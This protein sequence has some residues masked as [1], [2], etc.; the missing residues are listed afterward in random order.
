M[1]TEE[2]DSFADA[3]RLPELAERVR[4][5]LAEP[6]ATADRPVETPTAA[7]LQ[8]LRLLPTDLTLRQIGD[9]LY[10]S[11]N[12]VKT[13]S[14]N[15]YRKLGA[16]NR[17]EAVRHAAEAGLLTPRGTPRSLVSAAGP[18]TPV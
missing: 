9:E 13:H 4:Q 15:L 8:V 1:A 10:L 6:L 17:A 16:A 18:A 12:T 5:S 3:G 11:H 2:L 14:R 7:E